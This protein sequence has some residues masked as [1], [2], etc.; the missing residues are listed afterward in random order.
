MELE[1][2]IGAMQARIEEERQLEA[3]SKEGAGF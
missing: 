1:A 2:I 3:T